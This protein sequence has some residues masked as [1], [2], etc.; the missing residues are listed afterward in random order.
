[1]NYARVKWC[2]IVSIFLFCSIPARVAAVTI[3]PARQGL[4]ME[5]GT[6]HQVTVTITNTTGKRNL[7]EPEVDA[8]AINPETGRAVFGQSEEA[9]A[10]VTPSL[11][12]LVIDPGKKGRFIFTVTV[13]KDAEVRSRYLALFVTEKAPQGDVAINSRIGSLLFLHVSGLTH[14]Q[15]VTISFNSDK[16]ILFTP[17]ATFSLALKNTGTIHLIPEGSVTVM[18]NNAIIK[19]F[20]INDT[21][22]KVLPDGIWKASYQLNSLS[23]R[24]IGKLDAIAGV[25]YGLTNQELFVRTMVWYIP[26][27]LIVLVFAGVVIA[28]V[29]VRRKRFFAV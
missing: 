21:A 19:T 3:S 12:S 26:W 29:V 1:M 20:P 2:I 9:I 4:V 23:W 5:R 16:K 22:R 28:F 14:E 17:H 10:W 8:F 25:K 18:K 27:Q 15:L 24:D 13:S 6:T 7:Y 11:H